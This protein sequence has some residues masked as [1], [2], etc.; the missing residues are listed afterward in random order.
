MKFSDYVLPIIGVVCFLY[1]ICLVGWETPGG[2][3]SQKTKKRSKDDVFRAMAFRLITVP[4][5]LAIFPLAYLLGGWE[6]AT[7]SLVCKCILY[8]EDDPEVHVDPGDWGDGYRSCSRCRQKNYLPQ[9]SRG[10]G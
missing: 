3:L 2:I 4:V 9:G 8:V 10:T 6:T 5:G 7:H 1:F